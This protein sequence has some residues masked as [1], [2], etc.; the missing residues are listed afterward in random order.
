MKIGRFPGLHHNSLFGYRHP[1]K[2]DASRGS[3]FRQRQSQ[4]PVT[5]R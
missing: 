1:A 4:R 3:Q 2:M 5:M